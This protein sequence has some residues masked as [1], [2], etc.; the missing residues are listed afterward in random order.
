MTLFLDPLQD[1]SL[2]VTDSLR[3]MKDGLASVRVKY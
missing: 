2:R 1:V 3:V